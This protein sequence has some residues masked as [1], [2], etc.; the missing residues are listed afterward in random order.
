MTL[1]DPNAIQ[2]SNSTT[3]GSKD[4]PPELTLPFKRSVACLID[5]LIVGALSAATVYA[6]LAA[7][8]N[9]GDNAA[10]MPCICAFVI[11]FVD[12]VLACGGLLVIGALVA[13][14]TVSVNSIVF[15]ASTPLILN[16]LYHAIYES[17]ANKATPGKEIMQLKVTVRDGGRLSFNAAMRRNFAKVLTVTVSIMPFIYL[18]AGNRRQ[19]IHDRIAGAYVDT[20]KNVAANLMH[21]GAPNLVPE[22]AKIEKTACAGIGRRAVASILDSFLYYAIVQLTGSFCLVAMAHAVAHNA[23]IADVYIIIALLGFLCMLTTALTVSIFA[24]CEC[25]HL[26]AT[27]GKLVAGIRVVSEDGGRISFI[28]ALAKQFKQGLAYCSLYPI[29]GIITLVSMALPDLGPI[30]FLGG[31]LLFYV[32]YGLILCLSFKNGQT[33]MDRV[34]QRFVIRDL[35][36]KSTTYGIAAD[37]PTPIWENKG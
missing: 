28:Q 13:G 19:M 27:P 31:Y 26:Q 9:L 1:N 5:G 18:V 25:S 29:L 2:Q 7:S 24:A 12:V 16:H 35:P 6:F 15:G 37:T 33:L 11:G 22:I 4:T 30:L 21:A 17:S 8:N 36:P 14:H 23:V 32:G 20:K 34:C 3:S 10:L